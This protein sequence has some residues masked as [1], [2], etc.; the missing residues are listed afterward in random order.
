MQNKKEELLERLL[1]LTFK[2]IGSMEEIEERKFAK[3]RLGV[4][5]PVEGYQKGFG[6]YEKIISIENLREE[7]TRLFE[8]N[9]IPEVDV[10]LAI[11]MGL[12]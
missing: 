8:M 12:I 4:A 11:E 6:R 7:Y 2:S 3:C 1:E 5:A 10:S 9:L